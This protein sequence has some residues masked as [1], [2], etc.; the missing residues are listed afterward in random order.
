MDLLPKTSEQT[1]LAERCTDKWGQ[2]GAKHLEFLTSTDT[3]CNIF[4]L[5]TWGPCLLH[6][7]YPP[8]LRPWVQEQTH[9]G[10]QL[11]TERVD[12]RMCV[13]KKK[14]CPIFVVDCVFAA[15]AR[16]GDYIVYTSPC[17]LTLRHRLFY[18]PFLFVC[19]SFVLLSE[20]V[21]VYLYL[22]SGCM[23]F[24]VPFSRNLLQV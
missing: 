8:V 13:Q 7:L 14:T 3:C 17:C 21:V 23:G 1:G 16:C 4:T 24:K 2:S 22:I 11:F 6:P 12:V 19:L 10:M 15:A 5:L 20:G 9:R 18:L